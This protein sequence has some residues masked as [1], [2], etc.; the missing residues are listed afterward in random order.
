MASHIIASTINPADPQVL[1]KQNGGGD[2]PGY[3]PDK[4]QHVIENMHCY[5]CEADV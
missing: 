4:H 5:L 3:D 1:K 2:S